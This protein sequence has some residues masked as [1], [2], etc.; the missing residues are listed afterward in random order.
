MFYRCTL[1]FFFCISISPLRA[2]FDRVKFQRLTPG[3]RFSFM[4]EYFTRH[5]WEYYDSIMQPVRQSA[6]IADY[7]FMQSVARDPKNR[8]LLRMFWCLNQQGADFYAGLHQQ[9]AIDSIVSIRTYAHQHQLQAEEGIAWL[10]WCRFTL[11]QKGAMP[12]RQR[13]KLAYEGA[14]RGVALLERLPVQTEHQYRRATYDI[15]HHLWWLSLVF[16]RLEEYA[17]AR[18]MAVLGNQFIHPQL[19]TKEAHNYPFYK[20]E[21]LS[22]L[23]SSNLHLRDWEQARYWYQQAYAFARSQH[24]QLRQDVSYSNIGV[25]WQQQGAITAAEPYLNRVKALLQTRYAQQPYSALLS[26]DHFQ[27]TWYARFDRERFRQLPPEARFSLIDNYL[28]NHWRKLYFAIENDPRKNALSAD[29]QFM[30]REAKDPTS[31][32]LLRL[33]WVR[34]QHY[35]TVDKSARH[36]AMLDSLVAIRAY[37]HQ[38]KL[39][40]EEGISWLVWCKRILEYPNKIDHHTRRILVYDGAVKGLNLLESL[41][42]SV[43]QRYNGDTYDLTRHLWWMSMYFYQIEEYEL[44][45]RVATLGYRCAHPSLDNRVEDFLDLEYPRSYVFY[46]W[47]FQDDL[48]GYYLHT[49]QFRQAEKQYR[50]AY[51]FAKANQSSVEAGVSYGNIGVALSKQGKWAAAL[52]YLEHA[53]QVAQQENNRVSAFKAIVPLAQVYLQLKQHDKALPTLQ[54]AVAIYDPADM[55]VPEVDSLSLIPLLEGLGEVYQHRGDL[56]QALYYT[57]LANR[58]EE[59]RR[60]NDEAHI[61]RQKQ[62]RLEAEAYQAKLDIV[63]RARVQQVWVRNGAIGVLAS[64]VLVALVY[65]AYQHRRRRQ[66]ENQLALM[67]QDARTRTEQLEQLRQLAQTSAPATS[68]ATTPRIKELLQQAILT[69]ADWERFQ[70]SFERVYPKYLQRLRATHP[71]LTPAEIRLVC[72]SRLNLS[73]KEMATMLGV[74]ADTIVKTR[75]RIRKKV[76]LPEGADL[77]EA[78]GMV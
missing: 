76:N 56:K 68:P 30:R 73:T 39:R 14:L 36:D 29:Y 12:I 16:F 55:L 47:H 64:L 58:L 42:L 41:P 9:A 74:S 15:A 18:R 4:D 37:A 71:T 2:Q 25:A 24:D 54:R 61:F 38:N 49:G 75:Y 48:G 7:R 50:Q 52:P 53:M 27:F 44:L 11:D 62:A 72:L 65:V 59:K 10:L 20:W 19:E 43:L 31:T 8:C 70:Q 66:A 13:Q 78:F 3:E 32:T 23:G 33:F 5:W 34:N 60:L 51:A 69:E 67:A 40:A 35:L 63:E 17:L 22:L 21:F 46:K 57:Q 6:R 28:T 1:L 26:E 45:R 77:K